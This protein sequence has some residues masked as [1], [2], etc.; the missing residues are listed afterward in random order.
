MGVSVAQGVRIEGN[1]QVDVD[2]SGLVTRARLHHWVPVWLGTMVPEPSE[3]VLPKQ[4]IR[5][6]NHKFVVP[7]SWY[8]YEVGK[9]GS[10]VLVDKIFDSFVDAYTWAKNT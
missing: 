9:K 1:F 2:D 8:E 3:I 10:M 4:K 5:Y 7:S 6:E